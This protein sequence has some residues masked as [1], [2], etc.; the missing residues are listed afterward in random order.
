MKEKY[1]LFYIQKLV[2]KTQ[3]WFFAIFGF[4][5][6]Y[7]LYESSPLEVL[8]QQIITRGPAS[9][10]SAPLKLMD[11]L[12]LECE[13]SGTISAQSHQVR[14]ESLFCEKNFK[15]LKIINKT[16]GANAVVFKRSP[17]SY[18]TDYIHLN[19]GENH[20]SFS[21]ELKDKETL[22]ELVIIRK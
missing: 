16:T 11:T 3:L 10:D 4:A 14:L 21:Y 5:I 7:S 1:P 22:K 9:V 2:F 13:T 6:V 18:T 12:K 19:K 17:A 15:N 8:T 20:I